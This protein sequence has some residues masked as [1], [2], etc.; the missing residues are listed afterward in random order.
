M[1]RIF[2]Y[3]VKGVPMKKNF[4]ATIVVLA[5]FAVVTGCK[6]KPEET[7]P[8]PAPTTT[9]DTSG[10]DSSG[11]ATEDAA[12]PS[13]ELL[14]KRVVYFDLDRA[15]IRA[16]SQAVITA[17]ARYLAGASGQKVR[18]EGHADERGSREYNIGLGERR[19]Q[20]VRRALLLLGVAESQLATV[21]YGEERPAAAGS[22][23]Q[24]YS[25]NRR[26][27]IIYVK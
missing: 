19:S 2:D 12:G 5:A 4:V 3:N 22:D 8:A 21:S 9:T 24:A 16:D 20:A 26:V 10:V 27:E 17:H 15:D 7:P 18:L 6:T 23:E 11:A 25:L 14:S 1:N 13:G